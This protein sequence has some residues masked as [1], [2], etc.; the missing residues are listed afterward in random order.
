MKNASWNK[1]QAH[2]LIFKLLVEYICLA[3][4]LSKLTEIKNSP[5]LN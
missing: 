1:K 2:V 3:I 5:Y 4:E